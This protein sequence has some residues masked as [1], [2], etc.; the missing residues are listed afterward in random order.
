MATPIRTPSFLNLC[1]RTG[2]LFVLMGLCGAAALSGCVSRSF[3]V[4]NEEG[5]GT[6]DRWHAENNPSPFFNTRG[7]DMEFRF[8]D[9]KTIGKLSQE[10]WSDTYWPSY[11]GGVAVRWNAPDEAIGNAW[12]YSLHDKDKLKKMTDQQ[13]ARLSPAE[14]YDIFTGSYDYPL[15]KAERQRVKPE[16]AQWEGLCHAWAP[17]ALLF[18]EP[19][20][21]TLTNADGIKIPF[22]SSDVKALLIRALDAQ[23]DTAAFVGGRCNT[24]GRPMTPGGGSQDECRDVNAGAWHVILT[25]LVKPNSPT[26]GFVFD[27]DRESQVWNQ[28]IYSYTAT[29][30]PQASLHKNADPKTAKSIRV[31]SVVSYGVEVLPNWKPNISSGKNAISEVKFEYYLEVDSKG[32]IIG[33]EWISDKRP[34]FVWYST[35]RNTFTGFFDG[36]NK[37]Y[38]AS[39]GSRNPNP[40]PGSLT[41]GG[42][43]AMLHNDK[44]SM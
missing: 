32:N 39:V 42:W 27:V 15:V 21:V 13:I 17:G 8:D 14:K 4:E 6:Q 35:K 16:A 20:S 18:N 36:V 11:V 31:S 1:C 3:H 5:A 10:P 30:T 43:W 12:K 2:G 25:N 34:D 40:K 7:V 24:D 23:S 28:P 26:K 44:I 41:C 9:K 29:Y 22:G 19:V 38:A 33:G 37:I